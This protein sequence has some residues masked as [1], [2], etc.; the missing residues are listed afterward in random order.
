MRTTNSSSMPQQPDTPEIS[1]VIPAYNEEGN[2]GLV[3]DAIT[4][5]M[6][7]LKRAYEIIIVD[8]GSADNTVKDAKAYLSQYPIRILCLSRNFGKED[9]IMAGLEASLGKAVIVIDADLQEPVSMIRTFVEHWDNGYQMVYAVRANRDDESWLKTVASN[10]FYALLDRM[11]SV[12][13]PPHARDFRLMDRKVVDAVCS[14]PE[15]NRFMKGLFSWV[16]FKTK[17]VEVVIE[18]R[19]NGRS[20]FNYRRLF[21][22][23]L[24]GLTSFSDWPLRAWTLVGSIISI[25]SISYAG[26]I[27]L[28]T[29]IWGVHLPGWASLTVAI[30]FL[31]G[32]QLLSIGILGEYMSRIFCEVKGRPGHIVAQEISYL[33]EIES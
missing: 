25:A 17:E 29:L 8:D 24:T 32:I 11:T 6:Q 27:T 10:A 28:R 3:I 26:W 23:A 30:F 9:A 22:L 15:K 14:L 33:D 21:S 7:R 12:H 31:G 20:S 5:K 4:K 16:G 18:D 1:C 2:I 19:K 13:I